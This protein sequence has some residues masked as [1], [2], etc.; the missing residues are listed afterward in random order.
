MPVKRYLGG[1]FKRTYRR[2]AYVRPAAPRRPMAF[3]APVARRHRTMRGTTLVGTLS[4]PRNYGPYASLHG[5]PMPDRFNTSLIYSDTVE[6]NPS[7]GTLVHYDFRLNSLYDPDFSGAGHQPRGFDQ[8]MAFYQK[9]RV[10]ACKIDV[11]MLAPGPSD[12]ARA[13]WAVLVSGS[14][15]T[16]LWSQY[17]LE[18]HPNRVSPVYLTN[19]GTANTLPR[20]TG[21]VKLKDI[22]QVKDLEDDSDAQGSASSNPNRSAV[23]QLFCAA[24]D[25]SADPGNVPFQV[26]LTYYTTFYKTSDPGAS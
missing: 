6:L 7:N 2:P 10:Y 23:M 21:F 8:M 20:Y 16:P 24:L 4:V 17:I 12:N 1:Q 19:N 15:S 14:S 13:K 26:T 11:C 22:Y 25:G 5:S 3:S 9:F 18:E